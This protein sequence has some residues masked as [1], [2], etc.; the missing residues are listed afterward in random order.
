MPGKA[1][2]EIGQEGKILNIID[3]H[4]SV[5]GDVRGKFGF[6]PLEG[7]W[8]DGVLYGLKRLGSSYMY[9]YLVV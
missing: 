7:N 8:I 1:Y 3:T 4:M 6:G 2:V 9:T 5:H